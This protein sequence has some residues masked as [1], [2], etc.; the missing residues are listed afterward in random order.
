VS[1]LVCGGTALPAVA[2]PGQMNSVELEI[3][4]RLYGAG[5][6][7]TPR[8]AVR[9]YRSDFPARQAV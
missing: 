3:Y 9:G 1:C 5:L 8:Y 2:S 7:V 4:D 6:V